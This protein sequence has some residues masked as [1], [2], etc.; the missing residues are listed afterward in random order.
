MPGIMNRKLV[1]RHSTILTSFGIDDNCFFSSKM[2]KLQRQPKNNQKKPSN[3][4]HRS[5]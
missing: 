1:F 2:F 3:I 4:K 5:Q